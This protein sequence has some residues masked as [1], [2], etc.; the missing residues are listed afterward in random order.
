MF[1]ISEDNRKYALEVAAEANVDLRFEVC[2]ILEIDLAKVH[3]EG[4][5]GIGT[6]EGHEVYW[7]YDGVY[8][9]GA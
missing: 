4:Y 3:C 7:G 9:C 5:Y 1:D 8:F 2:D 6:G